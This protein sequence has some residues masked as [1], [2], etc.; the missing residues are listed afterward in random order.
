[1]IRI[2]LFAFL[3][4]H[5]AWLPIMAQWMHPPRGTSVRQPLADSVITGDRNFGRAAAGLMLVQLLP[6]SF[7]YFIV[8]EPTSRISFKS[9][10]KNLKP[11]SWDWD[12]GYFT[13][14][15]FAHPY[16]GG[17]Y[18]N[19]FRSNGYSFGQSSLAS[20]GGS[21]MWELVFETEAPAINDLVNTSAG[22]V[23]MGEM[24]HRIASRILKG[25]AYGIRRQG[26]EV[27]ATLVNPMLGLN[28][29]VTGRWG[30]PIAGAQPDSSVV[31]IDAETGIRRIDTQ[32]G[33]FLTKGVNSWFASFRLVYTTG[34]RE[35]KKPFED[36]MVYTEFADED[37]TRYS[38]R[39]NAMNIHG[40]LYGRGLL[41][42]VP[43]RH[44]WSVSANYDYFNN[45]SFFY[46]GQSVN[47]NF[48]SYFEIRRG[49]RLD[50]GVGA[51]AVLLAAVPDDHADPDK[52]RDYNYGPGV[53]VRAHG[54]LDIANRFRFSTRYNSGYLFTV[55]G[56]ESTHSLHTVSSDLSIRLF[57]G[58]YANIN[59][60][61]FTLK[62][63]Y[64]GHPEV[65]KNYP[66]GRIGLGYRKTFF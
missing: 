24:T 6:W 32:H 52:N 66:F 33:D 23:I 10:G 38:Y 56:T 64:R 63:N 55:S 12:D 7:N 60:G 17:L 62:G 50:A 41:E 21:L 19:A 1:M 35:E 46:G 14:N 8:H 65:D 34:D 45:K 49:I 57:D 58:F 3:F 2:V 15:Q 16:H 43:G 44:Q 59:S 30:K 25:E 27:L 51:G 61:Y 20:F 37:T 47:A 31:T 40:L 39:F 9:V 28:R 54:I 29:L 18:F 22:G 13:T 48:T 26:R 36:F 4:S 5:L 53:S 11:G 42:Q